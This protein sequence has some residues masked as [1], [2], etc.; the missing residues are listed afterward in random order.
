MTVKLNRKI[1]DPDV[2]IKKYFILLSLDIMVFFIKIIKI[3]INKFI[4][5]PTQIVIHDEEDNE[6]TI[7]IKNMGKIKMLFLIRKKI[8]IYNWIMNPIA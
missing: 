1:R 8:F 7:D 3:N 4:S 2:W 6:Y 5:I